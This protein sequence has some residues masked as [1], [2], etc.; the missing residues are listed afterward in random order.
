MSEGGIVILP[1]GATREDLVA[2]DQ[3][4]KYISDQALEWFQYLD[5]Y[6]KAIFDVA[7]PNGGLYLVTG[8]DKAV[9][10]SALSFWRA[11]GEEQTEG[12]LT[13]RYDKN[14]QTFSLDGSTAY[15]FDHDYHTAAEHQSTGMFLTPFIR[16][17][18]IGVSP[19]TWEEYLPPKTEIHTYNVATTPT[20]WALGTTQYDPIVRSAKLRTDI[21]TPGVS[22]RPH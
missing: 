5:G 2:T 15:E 11:E 22:V 9:A 10:W 20:L 8:V 7:I 6:N 13:V 19:T 16:G 21:A 1:Q 4:Y 18:R 12:T 3:L 17:L 14:T